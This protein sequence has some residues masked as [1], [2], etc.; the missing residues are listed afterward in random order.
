MVGQVVVVLDGGEGGGLA[1][2]SEVVDG[3]WF[4]EDGLDS[5]KGVSISKILN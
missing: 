5:L 1:E 3:N 4:W 2:K